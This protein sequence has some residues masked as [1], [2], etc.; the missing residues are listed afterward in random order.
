M[1]IHD[2]S[3]EVWVEDTF[4]GRRV[5]GKEYSL[6][7][8]GWVKGEKVHASSLGDVLCTTICDEW[9]KK[10]K[11]FYDWAIANGWQEGLTIERKD[12]NGNYSPEN[13]TWIPNSEQSK[14]RRC[15]LNNRGNSNG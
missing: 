3:L 6:A 4:T 15:T 7:E 5:C 2:K 10:P 8:L 9:Y 12:V 11:A 13:C 1:N 14:N